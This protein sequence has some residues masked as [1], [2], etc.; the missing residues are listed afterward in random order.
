MSQ[1]EKMGFADDPRRAN[2]VGEML[3]SLVPSIVAYTASLAHGDPVIP[4]LL[5]AMRTAS[6]RRRSLPKVLLKPPFMIR[7]VSV[8]SAESAHGRDEA[9]PVLAVKWIW[10]S[11]WIL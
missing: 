5:M 7:G 9:A 2:P 6:G 1:V 11:D 3:P 4:R 10:L 8:T